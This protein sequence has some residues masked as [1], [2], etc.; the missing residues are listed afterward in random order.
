MSTDERNS[1]SSGDCGRGLKIAFQ[2]L[3]TTIT[4]AGSRSES[5]D[6]SPFSRL[7]LKRFLS[8]LLSYFLTNFNFYSV[9]L[10]GGNLK[11]KYSQMIHRNKESRRSDIP[12]LSYNL[13][14]RG[15]EKKLKKSETR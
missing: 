1:R 11:F 6:G 8:L 5:C 2:E 12:R 9:H 15:N 14:E 7:L 3:I 4:R 10:L 13:L